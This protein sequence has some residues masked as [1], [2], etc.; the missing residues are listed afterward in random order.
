MV[1]LPFSKVLGDRISHSR[2]YRANHRNEIV[3]FSLNRHLVFTA[4][5]VLATAFRVRHRVR[6]VLDKQQELVV[7]HGS[8]VGDVHDILG[9][10]LESRGE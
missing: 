7:V 2:S 5:F 1:W 3:T 9:P 10:H 4:I 6:G 8:G